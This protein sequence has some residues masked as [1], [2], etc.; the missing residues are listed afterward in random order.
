VDTTASTLRKITASGQVTTIAGTTGVSG[1][2]DGPGTEALFN[3]P[4]GLALDSMGTL[5]IADTAASVIRKVTR[6]GVVSTLAGK[7]GVRGNVDGVGGAARFSTPTGIAVDHDG[8]LLVTD[9]WANNIR[10]ITPA[11]V[12]TT[13]VN[14]S[15]QRG[16]TDGP[17]DQARFVVPAGIAV[18]PAG[19]AYVCDYGNRTLRKI[20]PGGMVSTLAGR[21][22]RPSREPEDVPP[23]ADGT[24]ARAHFEGPIAVVADDT[25]NLYV[26][27]GT[28]I[29]KVTMEGR[30]TTIAGVPGQ[31]GIR[32]GPLPGRLENTSGL[33]LLDAHTL[34][35]TERFSVLKVVL[36]GQ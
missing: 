6:D 4:S 11:G 7:P 9:G 27:D 29:R 34:A 19:T 25:G 5:Y 2:K 8:N 31:S 3:N 30:V 13:W 1:H 35:V 32:L 22:P 23:S 24:G 15:G 14:R 26:A 36:E 33:A 10:K 18:D 16:S 20:T 28:T 21:A 12:V 17:V